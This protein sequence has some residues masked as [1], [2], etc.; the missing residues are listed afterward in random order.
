MIRLISTALL[1]TYVGFT[2]ADTIDDSL[3]GLDDMLYGDIPAVV[4]PARVEQPR[5]EV[6]STLSVLS[7]EFI[8][9]AVVC[10]CDTGLV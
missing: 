8:R 2:S 3:V 9:P 6:S 4:T 7:G 10:W 1:A 5:V